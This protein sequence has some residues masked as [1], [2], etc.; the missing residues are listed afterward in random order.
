MT[1]E[2]RIAI[3]ETRLARMRRLVAVLGVVSL[4]SLICAATQPRRTAEAQGA[5]RV[6]RANRFVVEDEGGQA[7]AELL[8]TTRG[9]SLIMAGNDRKPRLS[10]HLHN[11]KPGL[12][13]YD[14]KGNMSVTL[15]AAEGGPELKMFGGANRRAWLAAKEHEAWLHFSGENGRIRVSLAAGK[16]APLLRLFDKDGKPRIGLGVGEEGPLL[17]LF[18]EDGLPIWSAP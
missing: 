7:R 6:I 4:C 10:L 14:E 5:G 12:L 1:T 17:L 2:E 11:D 13:L 16:D 8:A 15:D 9:A 18:G 3:M